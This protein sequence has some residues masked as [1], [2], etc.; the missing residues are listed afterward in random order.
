MFEKVNP[1]VVSETK[2]ITMVTVILSAFLQSIFLIAGMWSYKV[3]LGNIYS[4]FFVILNFYLMG[5]SVA[6][7]V[8]KDEKEARNIVK[9][10]MSLRGLMLFVAVAVGVLLPVFDIFSVLIPLFFVRIAV[11][12]RPFIK[13]ESQKKGEKNE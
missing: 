10:S 4:G 5:L 3:L 1:T 11:F 6:K 8:E 12:L 7:A 13:K 9:T 2:Y